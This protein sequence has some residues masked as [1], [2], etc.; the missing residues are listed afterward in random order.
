MRRRSRSATRWLGEGKRPGN[1]GSHRLCVSGTA[2]SSTSWCSR[3]AAGRSIVETEPTDLLTETRVRRRVRVD[4][5]GFVVGAGCPPGWQGMAPGHGRRCRGGLGG[6]RCA[7]GTGWWS[8]AKDRGHVRGPQRAADGGRRP[9]GCPGPAQRAIGERHLDASRTARTRSASRD[10]AAAPVTAEPEPAVTRAEE[11]ARPRGQHRRGTRATWPDPRHGRVLHR[12]A[13]R[14]R[15]HRDPR[16]ERLVR[17]VARWSTAMPS[18]SGSLAC[19]PD[20]H[21]GPWRGVRRGRRGAGERRSG[22][23]SART[24]GSVTGIAGPDRRHRRP[25]RSGLV[26][27]ACRGRGRRGRDASPLGRR[28]V[29]PTSVPAPQPRCGCCSSA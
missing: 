4:Y 25:S 14:P 7:P 1:P 5:D 2:G 9:G 19:P 16:L 21:R 20:A 8:M 17:R 10:R 12:W 6:G 28:P 15:A 22:C 18:R 24:S 23:G 29:A 13:G 27:V 11:L 26:Y 3:R